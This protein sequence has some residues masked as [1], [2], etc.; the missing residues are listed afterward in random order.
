MKRQ[1]AFGVCLI[2]FMLSVG[3]VLFSAGFSSWGRKESAYYYIERGLVETNAPSI[4]NAIVWDFR[5]FD[6]L[7]EE[8]VL[9]TAAVGVFTVMVFGISEKGREGEKI[10]R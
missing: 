2:V 1:I 7:G 5:A 9:F 6:T 4:I 3:L 8:I 10:G